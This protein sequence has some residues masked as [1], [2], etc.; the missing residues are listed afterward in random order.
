[1]F[2]YYNTS[3]ISYLTVLTQDLVLIIR[4][5]Y[6]LIYISIKTDQKVYELH[7]SHIG[8]YTI[9]SSQVSVAFG[10]STHNLLL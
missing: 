5:N 2:N 1:M 6:F 9:H 7:R 4:Y 3:V 10:P 8:T